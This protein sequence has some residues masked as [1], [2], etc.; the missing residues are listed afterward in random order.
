MTSKSS[1]TSTCPVTCPSA[2]CA[3]R[4]SSAAT[5]CRPLAQAAALS[6]R[7]R[8]TTHSSKRP[9]WRD[10]VIAQIPAQ[11]PAVPST[12]AATVTRSHSTKASIPFPVAQDNDKVVA[13]S[14]F[15]FSGFKIPRQSFFSTPPSKRSA[16]L[17]T[18]ACAVSIAHF[19][20]VSTPD[21]LAPST[22]STTTS[23]SRACCFDRLMPSSSTAS[24]VSLAPA[25]SVT[26]TLCPFKSKPTSTASRVV[27]G[28]SE[29]IA[30]GRPARAFRSELFP[31]FGGP[32]RA[33]RTPDRVISP[34]GG[35]ARCKRSS[36]KSE[37]TIGANERNTSFPISSSSP[38][39]NEASQCACAFRNVVRQPEY[40]VRKLPPAI[41]NACRRCASVS[42]RNKSP[43][44]S[45]SVKSSLLF[46]NACSVNSPGSAC[47]TTPVST[48]TPPLLCSPPGGESVPSAR[49][50]ALT[51]AKLP[52]T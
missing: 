43:S 20:S 17:S 51:T 28:T 2:R 39:S 30:T 26:R 15:G 8:C 36:H 12:L 33:T 4:S 42:A 29:T 16:L 35:A 48:P 13:A 50:T 3:K 45:A 24:F 41:A 11:S 5:S 31:A 38:K 40:S 46:R 7:A 23:A 6:K 49:S 25:V 21:M 52:C 44:P 10:R 14:K 37:L 19:G 47:L 32:M 9:R 27:P 22:T 1:S 34:I 18:T